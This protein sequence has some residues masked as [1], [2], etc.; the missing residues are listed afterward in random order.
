MDKEVLAKRLEA[1][2]QELEER[3]DHDWSLRRMD[4]EQYHTLSIRIETYRD[5]ARIVRLKDRTHDDDR[6]E[7]RAMVR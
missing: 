1:F 7:A 2:A 5:A 6:R 4:S 3:T